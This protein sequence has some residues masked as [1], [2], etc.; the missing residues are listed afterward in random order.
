MANTDLNINF[1]LCVILVYKYKTKSP[2]SHIR[3]MAHLLGSCS[4][5]CTLRVPLTTKYRLAEVSCSKRRSLQCIYFYFDE[6]IGTFS[7]SVLPFPLEL[8]MLICVML[9]SDIYTVSKVDKQKTHAVEEETYM[10]AILHKMMSQHFVTFIS[11]CQTHRENIFV[12]FRWSF[13][14]T[15]TKLWL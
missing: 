3:L 10:S 7:L 5:S 9:N 6:K 15:E 14:M 8:K 1:F 13:I 11:W 12:N 2:S 4:L